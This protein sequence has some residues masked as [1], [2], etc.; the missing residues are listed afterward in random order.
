MEVKEDFLKEVVSVLDLK[1]KKIL[2][3]I[4]QREIYSK[5]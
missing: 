4:E 2:Q 1:G 5:Y 3:Q